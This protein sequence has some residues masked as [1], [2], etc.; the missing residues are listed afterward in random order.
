M[1]GLA[2][3]GAQAQQGGDAWRYA[4][5]GVWSMTRVWAR[6]KAGEEEV[7]VVVV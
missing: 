2:R 7:E 1:E 3:A 4:Q 6:V 5:S